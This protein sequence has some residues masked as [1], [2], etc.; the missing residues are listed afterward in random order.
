M[1]VSLAETQISTGGGERVK[2]ERK[3]K[4]MGGKK[5]SCSSGTGRAAVMLMRN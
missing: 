4:R 1:D 3:K 5:D 2:D